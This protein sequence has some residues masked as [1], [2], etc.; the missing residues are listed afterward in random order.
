MCV[1]WG[2]GGGRGR[3][4]GRG[5]VGG[6][7]FVGGPPVVPIHHIAPPAPANAAAG[8]GGSVGGPVGPRAR[9]RN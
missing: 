4:V 9:D 5:W 2:V 8:L 1:R 6:G 3:G 7:R